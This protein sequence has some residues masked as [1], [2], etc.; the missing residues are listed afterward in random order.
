MAAPA[1]ASTGQST[2]SVQTQVK[3]LRHGISWHRAKTWHY[4]DEAGLHRT[5]TAHAERRTASVAYLRWI[6]QRWSSRRIAARARLRAVLRA[7]LPWTTDWQTAV[8]IV[9]RDWPGSSRWLLACS[10]SEGGWGLW[11]SNYQGSGAGGWMQY[12]SGTFYGDLR[13]A[14]ALARQKHRPVPPRAADKWSS[15]LGQA[16]AAGWA[17]FHSRPPGKWTGSRC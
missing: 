6:E 12:M 7:G 13:G 10:S 2:T 4:Q 3:S 17:Y 8:R 5:P 1:G 14:L 9:Q 11:K 16:F 15:A